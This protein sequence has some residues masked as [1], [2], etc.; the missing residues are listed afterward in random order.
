MH[1]HDNREIRQSIVDVRQLVASK[2]GP[3]LVSASAGTELKRRIIPAG[4]RRQ[5]LPA[6][7]KERQ[8]A[9]CVDSKDGTFG[10]LLDSIPG[11]TA[12]ESSRI[13]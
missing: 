12:H 9:T 4:K 11:N 7:G 8:T 2:A 13:T 1:G 10:I 3:M 5:R 6:Q